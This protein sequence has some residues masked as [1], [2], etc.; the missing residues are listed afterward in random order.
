MA[1]VTKVN[2]FLGNFTTGALRSGS[3]PPHGDGLSNIQ[4]FKI[5][6]KN[7][8]DTAVDLADRD[9]D[10]AGEANQLVE[11]IIQELQPIAYE[12]TSTTGVINVIMDGH[13]VDA[14]SMQARIIPIVV[15]KVNGTTVALNDTTVE[16]A[17]GMTLSV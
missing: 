17:T 4:L 15:G 6:V 16:P 10:A 7:D 12:V 14:A 1:G 8:S 9:G 3:N 11:L 2:G 13:G 5:T